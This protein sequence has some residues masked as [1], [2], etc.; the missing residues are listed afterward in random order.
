MQRSAAVL[1]FLLAISIADSA[2][3][4]VYADDLAKCLVKSATAADQTTFVAWA[5][6]AMSNHP[7]VRR[8]SNFTAAQREDLTRTVGMLYER[9]MTVDCRAETVAA[10]KYEG[11]SAVAAGFNVL[12]QVAFRGLM[13]DPAVTSALESLGQVVDRKKFE[14]LGVEAGMAQPAKK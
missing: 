9:L 12:G 13:T 4:G 1:G 11:D 8:Y 6:G 2:R 14:A 5:F 7:A 10:L 3:A